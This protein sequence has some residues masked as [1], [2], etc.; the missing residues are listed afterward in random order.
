MIDTAHE[1]IKIA[2]K[3]VAW[4]YKGKDWRGGEICS[5][6]TQRMSI[7]LNKLT[8]TPLYDHKPIPF[9]DTALYAQRMETEKYKAMLFTSWQTIREQAK[10][11]NRLSN[12]VKNLNKKYKSAPAENKAPTLSVEGL[13][14]TYE[15]VVDYSDRRGVSIEEARAHLTSQ[16]KARNLNLYPTY[17]SMV[18]YSRNHYGVTI[19]KA[20]TP[21]LKDNILLA[22][23]RDN[24]STE[25]LKEILYT[26]VKEFK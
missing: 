5:L 1:D 8:E 16:N 3:P 15:S 12:K 4:M 6:S 17:E 23:S 11:L 20:R 26:I 9:Q 2:P 19:Q 25:Q 22:L 13:Y 10:G 7:E 18:D 21:L 24:L 14:P